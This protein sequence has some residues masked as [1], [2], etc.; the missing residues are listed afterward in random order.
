MSLTL[1]N[2]IWREVF[3]MSNDHESFGT[4]GYIVASVIAVIAL[5]VMFI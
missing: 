5:V 3:S 1:S 2:H 4:V